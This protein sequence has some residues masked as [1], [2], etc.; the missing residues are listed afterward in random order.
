[1]P[2]WPLSG[3]SYFVAGCFPCSC[4]EH[5]SFKH[6]Q[7]QCGSDLLWRGE[8]SLTVHLWELAVQYGVKP[9]RVVTTLVWVTD[10]ARGAGVLGE[11][12]VWRCSPL[13]GSLGDA[14]LLAFL[15]CWRQSH[16]MTSLPSAGFAKIP[17]EGA[18]LQLTR[19]HRHRAG[20]EE[21]NPAKSC[22]PC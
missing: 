17:R 5:L 6:L 13:A 4:L 15:D 11:G 12:T 10:Q 16:P 1:M 18:G 9:Q 21:L 7:S 8:I 3:F 14:P 19:T 22:F 20:T 2:A